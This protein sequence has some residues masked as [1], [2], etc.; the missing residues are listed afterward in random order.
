MLLF[1]DVVMIDGN[2]DGDGDGDGEGG[3]IMASKDSNGLVPP[4]SQGNSRLRWKRN[5]R[6]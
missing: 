3:D 2:D 5:M 6:A 1:G 4:S